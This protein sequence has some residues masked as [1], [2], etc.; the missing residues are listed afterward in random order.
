MEL[1]FLNLMKQLQKD[2][3]AG[4]DESGLI[5]MDKEASRFAKEVTFTKELDGVLGHI[6]QM[7]NEDAYT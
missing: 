6:Q 4:F 2:L 5:A 3:A 7:T 1:K